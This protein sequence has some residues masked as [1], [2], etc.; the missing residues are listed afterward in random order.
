MKSM[1]PP[2][3]GWRSPR[4]QQPVPPVLNPLATAFRFPRRL[5]AVALLA[6]A[7]F[8]GTAMAR[9][10]IQNVNTDKSRYNRSFGE[11]PTIYV[12]ITNNLGWNFGGPV[13]MTIR[14][15]GAQLHTASQTVYVNNGSSTSISFAWT[16]PTTDYRGYL[17]EISA[18]SVSTVIDTFNS[19]IDCSSDW[20]KF[21]RYG[22]VAKFGD[23]D[24]LGGCMWQLKNFHI[25]GIQFYDWGWKHHLPA[26][27]NG[28]T[29]WQ[30]IANRW[31]SRQKV[32]DG[33]SAA[34]NYGMVAMAYA[35]MNG[36]YDNYWSDG[37]GVQ[38]AWGAYT[39]NY[40]PSSY[41]PYDQLQ[42]G[43][44]GG[45]ATPRL[46]LFNPANTN[47]KNHI[48]GQMGQ[49]FSQFGFDGWHIDTLGYPGQT[50][51][52]E[53]N[54][55]TAVDTLP[56]FYNAAKTALDKKL[57]FNPVG[58]WGVN[59]VAENAGSLD[60]FY[61]ELWDDAEC[62]DYQDILTLTDTIRSKTSKAI[63]FA[64]YMN[65]AY[66]QSQSGLFN[67]PSVRLANATFFANG[68]S[69]IELGDYVQM[70]STEYFAYTGLVMSQSL[71]DAMRNYY[72][73]LVAYQNLLR[74]GTITGTGD[75][76]TGLSDSYS[77]VAGKVWKISKKQGSNFI[78]HLINLE[79]NWSTKWRA[80]NADY[81]APDRF[82]NF[83]MKI[84]YT[85]SLSGNAKVWVASPDRN[86]G[87]A[88]QLSYTAGADGA[89]TYV[90][91]TV[92]E[93]YYWNMV[94]LAP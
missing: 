45:W 89:G 47:W 64:A 1:L 34:H 62:D 38:L 6:A 13:T 77:A 50:Y 26:P 83:L 29:W 49:V 91:F 52:W 94:W 90:Q 79:N 54:P 88:Q 3:V 21:P 24:N 22:Y 74:D 17:V 58:M 9:P 56:N 70:L 42:W 67:E 72:S 61:N 46:Y 73:F 80:N 44:P 71:Y 43:M 51:T 27:P 55:I 28:W 2:S 76:Y 25:N 31:I 15:L 75:I 81:V 37:S 65:R 36:S 4:N 40:H 93:L 39:N 19:A 23:Y 59:K 66:A 16:P 33:I 60:I 78:A 18:T 30:D 82:Y 57:V 12:D 32:N 11:T 8:A 85:G 69:H 14:H 68:A 48:F 35:L 20:A 7:C 10:F 92:P 5:A 84:Y 63:V 86:N 87:S 53:A 41:T